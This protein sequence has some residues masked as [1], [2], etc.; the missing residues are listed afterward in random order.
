MPP[1]R[2][3]RARAPPP[4]AHQRRWLQAMP[5]GG[6]SLARSFSHRSTQ[7]HDLAQQPA[8]EDD[9]DGSDDEQL[10]R[11]GAV[12]L[13]RV[14]STAC[15]H[16][17][18]QKS[19]K[20]LPQGGPGSSGDARRP[21]A[22]GSPA[23]VLGF[24]ADYHTNRV[25]A[26][27]AFAVDCTGRQALGCPDAPPGVNTTWFVLSCAD[28]DTLKLW[29]TN[30]AGVATGEAPAEGVPPSTPAS[31]Y[32][33]PAATTAAAVPARC[34]R[35][36]TGHRGWVRDCC[37][38]QTAGGECVPACLGSLR[39][40][41]RRA[42]S[43]PESLTAGRSRVLVVR[44]TCRSRQIELGGRCRALPIAHSRSGAWRRA[45]ACSRSAS[46]RVLTAMIAPLWPPRSRTALPLIGKDGNQSVARRAP[47]A[48]QTLQH[49]LE[50]YPTPQR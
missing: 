6:A 1:P 13:E 12:P 42:F 16:A 8:A 35:T 43:G 30:A 27:C 47:S 5:Q 9:R 44:C 46:R 20:V 17:S 4:A 18:T 10:I 7:A 19:P 33:R 15:A 24:A 3:A 29:D 38:Y 28:D 23:R 49:H 25:K 36:L 40:C 48:P 22:A 41:A 21:S 37:V 50:P 11:Q 31:G 2:A 45:S 32:T 34:M 14:L 39:V 26:C